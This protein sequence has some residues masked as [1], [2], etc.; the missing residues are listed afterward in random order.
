VIVNDQRPAHAS[1]VFLEADYE[2]FPRHHA[3][4]V[5]SAAS[6]RQLRETRHTPTCRPA[7]VC[8]GH[9]TYTT[10]VDL[11]R[12]RALRSPDRLGYV[13]LRDGEAEEA[14][15]TF[16]EI[17]LRARAI[18]AELQRLNARGERA[19]L[20][21]PTSTDFVT[22]FFACLYAGVIA[23][24]V[25]LPGPAR[26][27]RSLPRLQAVARDADARL[28][29]TTSRTCAMLPAV[30]PA[31]P[32]LDALRWMATDSLPVHGGERWVDGNVGA[33]SIAFLQYTS[34]S[35][36]NPKGVVITHANLLHNQAA[37]RR[38]FEAT[39]E[40]VS[41]SW[42][43]LY[44]DMGLVGALLGALYTGGRSIFMSP[45]AF[46]QRPA[47]WLNAISRYRADVSGG[48]NFAFEHCLRRIA[49]DQRATLD[50]SRWSL[51]FTGAEPIRADTLHRFTQAFAP[52]GF[53][54]EAFFPCYG[55]AESTLF[56]TGASRHAPPV[57]RTLHADA[58]ARGEAVLAGESEDPARVRRVVGCGRSP[59][60]Q[61]IAIV[62]PETLRE[63]RAREIGEIWL[64]SPSVARGYWNQAAETEWTFR[65]RMLGVNDRAFLRT[66]DLGFLDG[67]E[68]FVTGRL[69]ELIIID[70]RNHYPQDVEQTAEASAPAIR[71][72]ACAA[73]AIEAAGE[74]RLVIVAEMQRRPEQYDGVD[75][76]GLAIRRAVAEVHGIEVHA[77][78]LTGPGS[79]PRT[80][81]GKLRRLACRDAFL[82]GTLDV[83]RGGEHVQPA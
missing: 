54:A 31:A 6:Q 74:D 23:V 66:G 76:V 2:S 61:R 62:D 7:D 5:G 10:I 29:L 42:L 45:D 37:I 53:R 12:E 15:L 52:C 83:F 75:D 73:F 51:A 47:R 20:L 1:E 60:D 81:S 40:S 44:H 58:L 24:P 41:V 28:I 18:A 68:L 77:V 26:L 57:V 46:L 80:T 27:A 17:D 3:S 48:P 19:L 55:L 21:Y 64:S 49:P 32:D 63:C 72:G 36:A 16:S 11:L 82:N 33:E 35:T 9:V 56:V 39:E 38:L 50:L 30:A 34:G 13:F 59:D 4:H 43:P 22:A 69:K 71:P 70:G 78:R 79:V 65:A 14:Q 67:G 25:P 8:D